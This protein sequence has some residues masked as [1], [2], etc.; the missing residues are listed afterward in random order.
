MFRYL[1]P[2]KEL[3]SLAMLACLSLVDL[4]FANS[5]K[6]CSPPASLNANNMKQTNRNLIRNFIWIKKDCLLSVVGLAILL[7][8]AVIVS[9]MDYP[10]GLLLILPS[11]IPHIVRLYTLRKDK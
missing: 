6:R 2:P 11:A 3:H 7:V 8:G 10:L 9:V 4:P 1:V 5:I